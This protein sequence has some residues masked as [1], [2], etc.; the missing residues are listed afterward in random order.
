LIPTRVL[1]R[2][3]DQTGRIVAEIHEITDEEAASF[4]TRLAGPRARR[5]GN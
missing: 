1:Y 4:L 3:I 5:V 2:I